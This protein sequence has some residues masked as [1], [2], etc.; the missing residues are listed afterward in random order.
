MVDLQN[1]KILELRFVQI[2]SDS[3][4]IQDCLHICCQI[5]KIIITEYILLIN[6]DGSFIN[7]IMKSL[8]SWSYKGDKMKI[9]NWSFSESVSL[10]LAKCWNGFGFDCD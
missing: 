3:G 7:L 2:A 8:Y 5:F 9:K 1:Q 10:I 4:Q 6:I